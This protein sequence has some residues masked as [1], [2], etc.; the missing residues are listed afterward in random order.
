[1]KLFKTNS[2]PSIEFYRE[3]FNSELPK[4]RD[5]GLPLATQNLLIPKPRELICM[6]EILDCITLLD[7]PAS[8]VIINRPVLFSFLFFLF[9][10]ILLSM[11]GELMIFKDYSP[12]IRVHLR[13][14][15]ISTLSSGPF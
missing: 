2:M 7:L 9:A 12:H 11:F 4:F 8:Y 5:T 15:P 3:Q 1:M 14:L 10:S 6:F 13:L